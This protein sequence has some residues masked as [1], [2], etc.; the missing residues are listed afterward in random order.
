MTTTGMASKA[1]GNAVTLAAI[2]AATAATGHA[3]AQVVFR[4]QHDVLVA[5]I[6]SGRAEGTLVGPAADLFSAQFKSQGTLLV[7]AAVLHPLKSPDCKRIRMVYTKKDVVGPRGPQDLVLTSD[8]NYCLDG[9]PPIGQ[10]L[11]K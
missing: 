7:T 4:K 3:T 2:L 10:E 1:M 5:A 11:P 8:L 9:R 6:R